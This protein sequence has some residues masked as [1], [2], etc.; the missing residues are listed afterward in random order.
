MFFN[1]HRNLRLAVHGDDFTLLGLDDDLNWFRTEIKKK[2]GTKVRGV[3]GPE[4]NDD[5]CIRILNRVIEWTDQ[6]IEYE[7][8]QRHAEAIVRDTGLEVS[9]KTATTPGVKST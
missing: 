1:E 6:G 7:A 2:F 5:K 3:I 9:A 8:D 4:P